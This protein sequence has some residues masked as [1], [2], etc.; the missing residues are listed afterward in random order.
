MADH[1]PGRAEAIRRGAEKIRGMN[2]FSNTFMS[3]ALRDRDACE[4]VLRKILRREDL[5]LTYAA[6]Q[7][8][9]PNLTSKDSYLDVYAENERENVIYNLEDQRKDTKE[10]TRRTRYYGAMIDKSSLD[11]GREYQE[12]PDVYV[13]YISETDIWHLGRTMYEVDYRLKE[14]GTPYEDGTHRIYV[15]AAVDDGSEV[16]QLM[17]YFKTADPNDMRH[18][19][20][21]RRVRYLK[22]E[23]RGEAEMDE[24]AEWIYNQAIMADKCEIA[25]RLHE[26][27]FETSKIA[28][29]VDT[30]ME[31]VCEWLGLAP[32]TA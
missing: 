25:Q 15:N 5:E 29:I 23:Q 27:G 21:S 30:S 22:S 17:Q 31:L 13:I 12:L 14:T 11:K 8:V 10:H 9:L 20:L 3:T 28:R 1:Q 24:V 6:T 32:V 18:G 16:A 2:L 4:Y 7:W 19:A 26:E